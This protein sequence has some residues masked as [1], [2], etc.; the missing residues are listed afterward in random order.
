[1]T[2]LE[3]LSWSEIKD[4]NYN[5]AVLPWGATEAHNYHLPYGTDNYETLQIGR[6]SVGKA[7]ESGA[8]AILLPLVPYGVNTG[9]QDIPFTI[10]LNPGTQQRILA[11]ILQSL[12]NS[13]VEKL[14][15]LNGH[16]GNDFKQML[17]EE[18][19]YFPEMILAS[20]NWFQALDKKKYFEHEGDHADEM[21]T[22]LM[23]YLQADLVKPL[24]TAGKEKARTFSVQALNE[25]WAW[26]ERKWIRVTPHTGIGNPEKASSDKGKI[27]FEALVTKI[28]AFI[29][30]LSRIPKE[31]FYK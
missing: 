21:E 8:D 7:N 14:L 20:C 18:G 1:M 28:S 4:S 12:E 6:A 19:Q 13:G 26:S 29:Q 2:S 30:E 5:L 17:R 24:E 22:S 11:D 31:D 27:Y 15:I 25:S 10:N 16:G 9:Q 23:L 3:R